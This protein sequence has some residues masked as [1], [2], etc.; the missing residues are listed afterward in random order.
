MTRRRLGKHGPMV[1]AIGLGCM[2]MSQSYGVRNDDDES[3]RTI[4]RAIEIGVTFL[5]TAAAYGA[6]ENER[7]V[8]RAVRLAHAHAS[9]A[10]GGDFEDFAEGALLHESASNHNLRTSD[11]PRAFGSK[12]SSLQYHCSRS[13]AV[14]P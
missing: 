6:G 10:D 9:E 2:G 5:D 11:A 8:G 3:I 13:G 4:H 1:S 14:R 12:I 7:L